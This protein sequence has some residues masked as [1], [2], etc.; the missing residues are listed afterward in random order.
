MKTNI[1]FISNKFIFIVSLF[2]L[3]LVN[4]MEAQTI[5]PKPL[6]FTSIC[7]DAGVDYFLEFTYTGF[8]GGTTFTVEL[9]DKTGSYTTPTIVNPAGGTATD[10]NAST[11]RITFQIPLTLQGSVNYKIR[12]KSS[13]GGVIS[14]DFFS[15]YDAIVNP[16][17]SQNIAIYY[18]VTNKS[19][20][21][22]GGTG[23][24]ALCNGNSVT[25][26]IDA[27][28]ESLL[29]P[30]LE[31]QLYKGPLGTTDPLSTA[32]VAG[33]PTTST[34]F[35]VNSTGTYYV[36]IDY[37]KGC[38]VS[39]I[40]YSQLVNVNVSSGGGSITGSVNIISPAIIPPSGSITVTATTNAT[41][42]T[43]QWYYNGAPIPNATFSS[44]DATLAGSYK[45]II[46]ESTSCQ[47]TTE[48]PFVLKLNNPLGG[49]NIPNLV[50]PNNDG[51][52]DTWAIPDEFTAGNNTEVLLLSA[53]GEVV[54]RTTN[55]QNNWPEN[56]ID[57]KS[58]NPVYYYI[59]SKEGQE[60]KKGSITVVK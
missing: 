25:L 46:T 2:I 19:F 53:T 55:Y 20:S 1:T 18:K 12:V 36:R 22:N 23:N 37:G 42:P 8:P 24:I 43:F 29:Y 44:Y 7:A 5:T 38:I 4:K 48:V 28:S 32:F 9:S 39:S 45:V 54:L 52:N 51:T 47:V 41:S 30:Y 35:P 33:S 50:S 58:V 10:I 56:S 59:I 34:T 31:Y 16:F 14:S 60:V 27:G 3:L 6:P 49:A 11:K 26:T 17:P 40:A 21:L 57:F 13:T 15:A